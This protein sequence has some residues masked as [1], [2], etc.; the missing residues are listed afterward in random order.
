MFESSNLSAG[1]RSALKQIGGRLLHPARV[2]ASFAHGTSDVM[3][4][5]AST[6]RTDESSQFSKPGRLQNLL[7][8]SRVIFG[9]LPSYNCHPVFELLERN[10]VLSKIAAEVGYMRVL[11]TV[12]DI[13]AIE[14]VAR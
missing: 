9:G 11:L 4:P 1:T 13:A 7:G 12:A 8:I 10:L 6:S 2:S 3:L 14:A 5:E